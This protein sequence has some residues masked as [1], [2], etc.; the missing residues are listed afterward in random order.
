VSAHALIFWTAGAVLVYTYLLFPAVLFVVSRIFRFKSRTDH[1]YLPG[2]T[3]LI[4]AYNEQAVI[5]QK[6]EN[7]LALDYPPEKLEIRIGSDASTDD[8]DTILGSFGARITF[9]RFNERQG[10]SNILNALAAGM[11]GEI[12]V[13]SDANTMFA[14]DAIRKLVRHFADERVGGVCG[15]LILEGETAAVLGNF[16]KRYWKMESGLKV[17]EGMLGRVMGANGAIYAIRKSLFRPIPTRRLLMDD[18]F[19]ALQVL[20]QHKKIVY[21]TVAYAT[22]SPS[23]RDAGEFNRKIRIARAN[24]NFLWTQPGVFFTYDLIFLFLFI[25]HKLLRWVAP[26]ILIGVLVLNALLV[27]TAELYLYLLAAQGV[28]Y[29]TALIGLFLRKAVPLLAAPYYFVSMNAAMLIGFFKSLL[30]R[31][32]ISWKRVER[33]P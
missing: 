25:S 4:A 26:F 33:E 24:F 27:C 29:F 22:E 11:T 28:F 32:S 12:I 15:R 3:V 16:E 13:F 21:E 14:P 8:T 19:M 6:V 5:R 7:A 23:L 30:P 20:G 31:Q 10:K 18:F 2:V 9:I 17:W 1:E